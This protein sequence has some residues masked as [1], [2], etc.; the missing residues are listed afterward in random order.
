MNCDG[1]RPGAALDGSTL[2]SVIDQDLTGESYQGHEDPLSV[3]RALTGR[4]HES[5][6]R[7][8]HHLCGIKREAG[9]LAASDSRGNDLADLSVQ[10]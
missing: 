3:L 10:L 7:L 6:V 2:S 9:V 5:N 8:V 4:P 1:A